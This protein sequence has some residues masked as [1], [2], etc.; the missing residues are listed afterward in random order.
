MLSVRGEVER[1]AEDGAAAA[2]VGSSDG[3]GYAVEVE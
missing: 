2:E 1:I 3:K